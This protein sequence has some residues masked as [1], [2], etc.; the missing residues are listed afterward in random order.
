MQENIK[1]CCTVEPDIETKKE[2]LRNITSSKFVDNGETINIGVI[3]HV[4]Y[5]GYNK[6]DV[7]LDIAHVNSI[8]NKDFNKNADNF[9]NGA[10]V[11]QYEIPNVKTYPLLPYKKRYSYLKITRKIR[12]NRRLYLRYLRTNSK[13]RVLNARIDLINRK[14]KKIN[15]TRIRYNNKVLG[16][17]RNIKNTVD[18]FNNIY[19]QYVERA[20]SLNINFNHI[21]TIYKP[22][23]NIKTDD[24]SVIDN[25]V[26]INGSPAI[27]PDTHLNVWIV[28]FD[29]GLLGYAQFPW[30]TNKLTDGVVV[31]R[32]AFGRNPSYQDYNLNKTIIHEIGHWLGLYHTFQSSF[33][34]Q[35]GVFDNNEDGIISLGEKTGDLIEDTPIQSN[36]TYGDPYLTPTTW[37]NTKYKG[38]TYY[39]MYI[40]FMDY[41]NDRNMFMLT[42]EQCAK[43]R[44]MINHYRSSYML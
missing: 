16:K 20:G 7:D 42:K 12:R 39:H 22:L 8:L 19:N 23:N 3:Y 13:R 37:A 10:D 18:S 31:S 21:Q 33:S 43:A 11:Y 4:C 26:K 28:N 30:D 40:N 27:T 17:Y 32:Y 6:D 2:I 14:R 41:T 15:R 5:N 36:P 9:N 1:V 44:L 25:I 29:N 24:I 38:K 34:G 35:D